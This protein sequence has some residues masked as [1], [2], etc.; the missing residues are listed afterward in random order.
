MISE[1]ELKTI[2]SSLPL[3]PG[4]YIYRDVSGTVIYVGKAKNLKKRVTSYFHK[5]HLDPHI[6]NLVRSITN[7]EYF[8][9][10]SEL[11]AFILE[12]NLIKKYMPY[13]NRDLKDDKNYIW[14]M[15][16][17]KEDF[18]RLQ[19]VRNKRSKTALYLG[20][21]HHTMPVKRILKRLRKIY[22]YRTCNRIITQSV[23][24]E[25]N[26][27]DIKSSDPNPCLYFHLGLCQAPCAG[28]VNSNKYRKNING[29]N[30]FF[31]KG[32]NSLVK[33]LL[34]SMK[35]YSVNLDFEKA[36]E[37]RNKIQDL[38][39]IKQ[40][41]SVETELTDEFDLDIEKNKKSIN[42][43]EEIIH[44]ISNG[45]LIYKDKFK[46]ECFDIS[47]IQGTNA[48]GSMVVFV[49]GK[50]T[51]NLY[52]KFKIKTK[53][54]P[55]DFA[56]MT[57]VLKRRFKHRDSKTDDSFSKFPDL[58]IVDGGKGQLSSA[59]KVLTDIGVTI[60]LIGLAKKNEDIFMLT[61]NN[62]ELEFSQRRLR[63]ASD[64]YF[65]IQRIRDESH[66][67]AIN[68]HR[69]LRSVGQTASILDDVPGIGKL[70]K[71]RLLQ[72]FGTV[73]GI[74]KAK[75]KDL[76]VIIKNNTSINN[77]LKILETSD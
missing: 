11:E 16:D 13:Y 34:E 45:D 47:N 24:K 31:T 71:K 41:V 3:E 39:Y 33:E 77:L 69:K 42:A 49:D 43:V 66:R 53:T 19:V 68:Y 6:G 56:M 32:H 55:D 75:R 73:E 63:Y 29:I 26:E 40:R 15:I 62:G 46:I 48:V 70:T 10:D 74:K 65:L 50:P 2:L 17:R 22:P 9:T 30:T 35:K 36:A 37:V 61:D 21:Y 38:E 27:I 25:T 59:H 52:R 64:G 4:C 54:T 72:A 20:P 7:I 51:K 44:K 8:V 58:V 57:E 67:F 14:I 23:N 1:S 76:E 28:L 60:P 18:P 12:T 5:D